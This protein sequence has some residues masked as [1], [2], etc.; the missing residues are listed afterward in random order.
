M[1]KSTFTNVQDLPTE[2]EQTEPMLS[3]RLESDHRDEAGYKALTELL[4]QARYNGRPYR[5]NLEIAVTRREL[6]RL[7][8]RGLNPV[9]AYHSAES[10]VVGP[11]DPATEPAALEL[12]MEHIEELTDWSILTKAFD[13]NLALDKR[14]GLYSLAAR[15]WIT[16][17]PERPDIAEFNPPRTLAEVERDLADYGLKLEDFFYDIDKE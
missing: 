1:S 5:L 10:S 14:H 8:A 6:D 4:G 9:P 16:A 12:L 15:R 11:L 3:V 17:D 13:E 2:R 7:Q